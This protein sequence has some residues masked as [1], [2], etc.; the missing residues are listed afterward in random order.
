[1]PFISQ[2]SGRPAIL[3]ISYPE[4]LVAVGN[5]FCLKSNDR[6]RFDPVQQAGTGWPEFHL[7]EQVKKI[8]PFTV[9]ALFHLDTV[10]AI[11][12]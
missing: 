4:C 8:N 1:M 10:P 3:G 11:L 2:P 9:K 6:N 7:L 12:S 5:D